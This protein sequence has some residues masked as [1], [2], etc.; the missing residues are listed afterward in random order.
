MSRR[1][2]LAFGIVILLPQ[3]A[4][5]G[6]PSVTFTDVA[7]MRLNAISFFLMGFLVSAAL[8]RLLWN[9][10]AADFP[11]LP[12][13]TYGKACG[14]TFLW[15]LL[16]IIVLTMISGARELMT[17]GAW[18]KDGLTYKLTEDDETQGSSNELHRER[19]LKL[20]MFGEEL[21]RWADK[22]DGRYP[23]REEALR[24]I[25]EAIW[26]VPQTL[27]LRYI[28]TGEPEAKG[29]QTLAHEPNIF[30]DAPLELL[31]VGAIEQR[32][33]AASVER[34]AE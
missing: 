30:F 10:L 29:N 31:V 5:A 21:R 16:F 27:D 22:N 4:L 24:D 12:R 28:Y 1:I 2:V 14:L 32:K 8:I 6:M 23:T 25:P 26:R 19:K 18:K 9:Y 20:A 15:G 13:L 7:R 33:A 34:M 3:I 11:R 17:P